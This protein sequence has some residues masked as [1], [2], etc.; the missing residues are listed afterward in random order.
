MILNFIKV[1]T[2]QVVSKEEVPRI[3]LQFLHFPSHM[4]TPPMRL[5]VPSCFFVMQRT[6]NEPIEWQV[7][8][9]IVADTFRKEW[10]EAL[11]LIKSTKRHS[12]TEKKIIDLSK[13]IQKVSITLFT[14]IFLF[15]NL[16]KMYPKITP[17]SHGPILKQKK[18]N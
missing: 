6:M 16:K 18:F 4:K 8:Q 14:R 15:F 2:C 12:N 11:R 9:L 1:L 3:F 17:M 13:L 10:Q 7:F 5:Q